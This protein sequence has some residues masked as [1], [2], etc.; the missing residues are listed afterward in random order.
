MHRPFNFLVNAALLS[1]PR[2]EPIQKK[3]IVRGAV[4]SKSRPFCYSKAQEEN[5][6]KKRVIAAAASLIGAAGYVAY[7][8]KKKKRSYSRFNEIP[9]G[10][11]KGGLTKGI[12]VL[13]G[14]S[15]RG[16]YTAGV[17]D[18]LMENG[19]NMQA[20]IGVSAGS[21]NGAGYLARQ[22]GRSARFNLSN[23]FDS[24]YLG[25]RAF[26]QS[27]SLFGLNYMFSDKVNVEPLNWKG[28]NDPRRRFV[29]VATDIDTGKPAFLQRG[30]VS[31]IINAIR[32]SCGL[33]I[34]SAPVFL[35]G[36]YYLDGGCSLNIPYQWA[37]KQGY[38]K[39]IVVR[40]RARGFHV[41]LDREES[42]LT[43]V[44][45]KQYRN[46]PAF[47]SALLHRDER[48]NRECE[49]LEELER[50]EKLFCIAPSIPP[51]V[52]R[53]ESDLEKLGDL[54]MLGRKDAADSLSDLKNYLEK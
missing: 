8:R 50:R 42:L 31:S 29:C 54:Y 28:L 23:R 26:L 48:Y 38:E 33:P 20:V 4:L 7:K 45:K 13:E 30:R 27:K 16:L 21:L 39:I 1:R 41:D 51:K 52:K 12:I 36:H 53:T 9:K 11:A 24:R 47:L 25:L 37:I 35:D 22:I 6:M 32:A 3:D 46:K 17:L 10:I 2:A 34:V 5:N 43:K 49:V 15:L 19:I 18:V 14:G 44:Q 40:T